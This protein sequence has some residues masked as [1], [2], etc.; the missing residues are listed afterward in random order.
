MT[1]EVGKNR[2]EALADA[3]ESADLIRYYSQQM[4]DAS[5]R[6][7]MGSFP[8]QK[9]RDIS[10]LRSSACCALQL[11]SLSAGM[12]AGAL[13]AGNTVV[14]KPSPTLRP[15]S[16]APRICAGRAFRAR[17]LH[18]LQRRSGKTL[19]AGPKVSESSSVEKWAAICRAS[20]PRPAC[21][22]SSEEEPDLVTASADL[23]KG[24]GRRHAGLS[25]SRDRSAVPRAGSTC[26]GTW[27]R[28]SGSF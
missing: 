1:L 6:R 3:E 19:V 27:P 17:W 26:M 16:Q 14:F 12:S 28:A 7:P 21:F 4:E 15:R 13:L 5:L 11:L 24:G 9:T 25:D 22:S 23:E 8:R 2:F 18:R 10:N 20:Q